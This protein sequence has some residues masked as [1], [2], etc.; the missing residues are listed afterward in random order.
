[1]GQPNR[2]GGLPKALKVIFATVERGSVAIVR[3]R[4]KESLRDLVEGAEANAVLI[5]IAPIFP[6]KNNTELH[7]IIFDLLMHPFGL[8]LGFVDISSIR[9]EIDTHGQ[10]SGGGTGDILLE[11]LV[12]DVLV[13]IAIANANKDEFHATLFDGGPVNVA[14]PRRNVNA[15]FSISS[16]ALLDDFGKGR[17]RCGRGGRRVAGVWAGG[18]DS[19]GEGVS[20]AIAAG[21]SNAI[22]EVVIPYLVDVVFTE[23]F[24]HRMVIE[25]VAT[26]HK[27]SKVTFVA[28]HDSIITLAINSGW[29]DVGYGNGESAFASTVFDVDIFKG[30]FLWTESFSIDGKII[31]HATIQVFQKIGNFN[32]GAERDSEIICRLK[33]DGS[34]IE[35]TI[36][37]DVV[38]N[39]NASKNPDNKEQ[40]YTKNH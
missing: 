16:F 31:H 3:N 39:K 21:V 33:R 40:N 11:L 19:E 37:G 30:D 7:G 18:Y 4:V 12:E 8:L 6:V 32:F 25:I 24:A 5:E 28:T 34:S 27:I 15:D 23:D 13:F 38:R 20:G 36:F 35:T 17:A 29:R 14:L 10:A 9:V 2:C 1:M 22:F 26:E